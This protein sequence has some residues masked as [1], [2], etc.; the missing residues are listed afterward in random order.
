[1]CAPNVHL[2]IMAALWDAVNNG[3]ARPACCAGCST[4]L[5]AACAHTVQ[6]IVTAPGEAFA[7]GSDLFKALLDAAKELKGK[8]IFVS[9]AGEQG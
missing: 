7:K 5:P 6:V 1:M 8:I 4:D 9:A 2:A 3:C